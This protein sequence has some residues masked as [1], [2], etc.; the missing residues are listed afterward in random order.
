[1][2]LM[3]SGFGV[4]ILSL[5]AIA[6]GYFGGRPLLE[7]MEFSRAEADV[8]STRQELSTVED[9]S[10]VFRHV[11]KVVEPS[12]VNIQVHK[13]VKEARSGIPEDQLRRF[14]QEHGLGDVPNFGDN[15]NNDNEQG[16]EEVG[17]GSGVI[18]DAEN[19]Y[20]YILTNN[21][22]AGDDSVIDK[23]T[24]AD[25][26]VLHKD[27][28]K[29]LGADAKSDL[30]VVQIKADRLIPAHWGNSDDL[31]KGDWVMAFGSPFGYVGSMTHGIVSALHRNSVTGGQD[32]ENFIQV[33]APINPGNSGGP[34]VNI[35]GEVIGI[36]T[37]I[38][39]VSGGFQ[40]IGFAIPSDSA[41]LIYTSLREHGKVVRGWLGVSIRSV[42]DQ[43]DLAKSFGYQGDSGVMVE[44]TFPNTPASGKLLDG[45]IITEVNGQ[46]V[47]DV[48]EL[49]NLIA[50]TPPN[51]AVKLHLFRDQKEMDVQITLGDQP[52][53]LAALIGGNDQGD[54]GAAPND[55]AQA[56]VAMGMTFKTLD[57]DTAQSL[58]LNDVRSG[59]V[60]TA[61]ERN[62]AAAQ[63]GLQEGDVITE[64]GRT[65]VHTADEAV[66]A[67]KKV[68]LSKGVRL[69]IATKAGSEFVFLQQD[70]PSQ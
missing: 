35:H 3:R 10:T 63:A 54:N 38:A 27:D 11:G 58:G 36:N 41:K 33:D 57:A 15:G 37:A 64:V 9:L 32:Y 19:G 31:E 66:D 2:K 43:P 39:T 16:L 13:T 6:A 55:Q 68:D 14:F 24:L 51:T 48:T 30:A 7:R 23:V 12:V 52:E 61:V 22:V 5:S 17:T 21:H 46:P 65:P 69:Y 70:Q 56:P 50:Q 60:I 1:M 18:M 62:S 28:C 29:L 44:Q 47:S 25:G 20:G 53:N 49:R 40:G 59:A 8:Q 42:S 26:R 45:D 4:S 34:L 67:L